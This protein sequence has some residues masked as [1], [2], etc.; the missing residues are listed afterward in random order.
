VMLFNTSEFIFPPLAV[1]LHFLAMQ[2]SNDHGR[3]RRR[4]ARRSRGSDQDGRATELPG[5]S[6]HAPLASISRT[7]EPPLR[8]PRPRPIH[9]G[10]GRWPYRDVD[11]RRPCEGRDSGRRPERADQL[12]PS[13]R[14]ASRPSSSISRDCHGRSWGC[15]QDL[16]NVRIVVLAPKRTHRPET[17][18]DR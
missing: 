12:A 16:L 14:L 8:D 1:T 15:G 6:S 2:R 5:A 17:L 18:G 13:M 3:G 9:K 7:S 11:A 10:N 4:R